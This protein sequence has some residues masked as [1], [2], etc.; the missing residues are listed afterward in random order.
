MK[1]VV[2]DG[3]H[4]SAWLSVLIGGCVGVKALQVIKYS[5]QWMCSARLADLP[6]DL[7]KAVALCKIIRML[8]S[9]VGFKDGTDFS[10]D[11]A[12]FTL[13]A[14]VKINQGLPV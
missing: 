5:G 9:V 12:W 8:I 6:D 13:G 4:Y 3:R 10:D 11:V 14:G 1:L 7:S 2:V